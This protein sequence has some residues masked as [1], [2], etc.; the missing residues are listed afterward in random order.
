MY[1]KGWPA[2]TQLCMASG[3]LFENNTTGLIIGR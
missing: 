1:V 2:I 3:L